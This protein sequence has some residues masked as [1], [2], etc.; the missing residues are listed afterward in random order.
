MKALSRYGEIGKRAG[1]QVSRSERRCRVNLYFGGSSPS[2]CTQ[3]V[4]P[5]SLTEIVVKDVVRIY[6]VAAML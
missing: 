4:R 2:I 6:N 5:C 3:A 1:L